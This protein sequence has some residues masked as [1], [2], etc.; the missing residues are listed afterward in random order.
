MCDGDTP[1]RSRAVTLTGPGT[2]RRAFPTWFTGHTLA[3]R[4]W[5]GAQLPETARS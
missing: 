1:L 5:T 4:R 2:L 3:Q